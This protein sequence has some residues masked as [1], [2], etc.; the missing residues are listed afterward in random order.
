MKRPYQV[1]AGVFI[2]L[3]V[4]V[5][6]ESLELRFYTSFGPGPGFFPFLLAIILGLLAAV[7]LYQATFGKQDAIQADFFVTRTQYLRMVAIVVAVIWIIF[8]MN[9]LGFRLTMF[10]FFVFLLSVLGRH[11]PITII[12]LATACSFGAYHVF[13]KWLLVPLP[14]GPFSF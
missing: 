14:A 4:F 7:M 3:S 1:T 2:L 13:A 6:R 9:A 12:L 5:A 11:N 10:F 8:A